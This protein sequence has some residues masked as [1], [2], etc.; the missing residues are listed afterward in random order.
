MAIYWKDCFREYWIGGCVAT[1]ALLPGFVQAEELSRDGPTAFRLH[2]DGL[3][4]ADIADFNYGR[5]LFHHVWT[6]VAYADKSVSGLG[7]L[8]N[9]TACAACHIR[10]GRGHPPE[11]DSLDTTS[12]VMRLSTGFEEING[13]N[14]VMAD[15]VYGFQ[16]QDRAVEGFNAEGHI[17]VSYSE[18]NLSFA[19]G[20]VISLRTPSYSFVD[21]NYGPVDSDIHLGPRIAPQLIG[22]GLLED[23]PVSRL[24]ELQD[25]DDANADGISG[26]INWGVADANGERLPGRFGWKLTTESVRIQSNMAAN[27]DMGLATE[28][29]RSMAGDCTN[30]QIDCQELSR[31]IHFGKSVELDD[32]E[33]RKLTVYTSNLRVPDVRTEQDPQALLGREV[34]TNIGCAACHVPSHSL[35]N[36]EEIFP[37]TDLLLH[38]MGEGLADGIVVGNADYREWRTPPL[39]G[40]GFTRIVSGHTFFLHDGRA[41]NLNEAIAWHGGEGIVARDKFL[42]LDSQERQNLLAF[43]NSI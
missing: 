11:V 9:A 26:E 33:M 41:R 43:I 32:N 2:K 10:D 37:Y 38:D 14:V 40:I 16:F 4:S 36:G 18:Q 17:S 23:I 35:E 29:V 42:A 34:F 8:Y 5:G 7:P 25:I 13:Y 30:S 3:N 15:P 19:D 1:L 6:P 24:L 12:F 31:P 27:A 22:L 20:T 39:W 28:M 21:L